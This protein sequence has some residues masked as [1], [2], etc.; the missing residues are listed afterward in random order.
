M[1]INWEVTQVDV[2]TVSEL[3]ENQRLKPFFVERTKWNLARL[4]PKV[5]KN[6]FWRAMVC[7]RLTTLAK[8]GPGTNLAKFQ[9]L[10]PFPLAYETMLRRTSKKDFIYRSLVENGVGRHP[11]KISEELAR[12]FSVLKS[13]RGTKLLLQ[14]N[15]LV[16]RVCRNTEI[17]VAHIVNDLF[18]GFGPKQSRNVLQALGLTRYEIPLDSRVTKW[19]N[20]NL[21]FPFCV[22]PTALSDKH[23]YRLIS[24][25]ICVLCSKANV[26]PCLLDAAIFSARDGDGWTPEALRAMRC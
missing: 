12:N 3:I 14:C 5:T 18:K 1:N 25:A 19:L 23:I 10:K 22:T 9:A 21:D 17:F 11:N 15:I 6:R 20:E 26:V 24:D 13:R 7:M 2:Q 8:S 16:P 4:R